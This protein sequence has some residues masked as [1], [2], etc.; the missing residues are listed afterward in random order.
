MKY[1]DIIL[2][3]DQTHFLY[4]RKNIFN[5]IFLQALKFHSEG[6]AAVQD[7][8]GWYHIDMKGQE[9]YHTRYDRVFG[10]YFNRAAV[11]DKLVWYHIDIKG[12]RVYPE[13][14]LWCGNFQENA[15]TVRN[16]QNKYFHIDIYGKV[17]YKEEY[18]YAGDYRDGFACVRLDSGLFVH[19][20]EVG[21]RIN[22]KEFIDLGVFHKG[23][24]TAKDHKGWFHINCSGKQLYEARFFSIEP[25][26]NGFS[27]VETF[28]NRKIIIDELGKE[29]MGI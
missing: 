23:I 21:K 13:N 9:I 4:D 19:I 16:F 11:I 15:C 17:I 12:N 29:V 27:V 2:S 8:K 26:Y 14:Y 10:F 18:K 5:K 7:E 1:T 25:F 6:I 24:A 28:E 22:N 20:D 3:K